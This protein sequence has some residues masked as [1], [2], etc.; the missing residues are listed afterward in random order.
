M[1]SYLVVFGYGFFEFMQVRV[2]VREVESQLLI[3]TR[4]LVFNSFHVVS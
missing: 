3:I 2:S 4:T 1:G